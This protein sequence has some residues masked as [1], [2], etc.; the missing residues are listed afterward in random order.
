MINCRH[1]KLGPGALPGFV[2]WR[3]AAN[4]VAVK[5][6]DILTGVTGGFLHQSDTFFDTSPADS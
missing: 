3:V 1:T 5:S 6:L 2:L 4:S